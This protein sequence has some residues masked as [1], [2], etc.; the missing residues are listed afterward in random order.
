M[1]GKQGACIL[2]E[3]KVVN[4]PVKTAVRNICLFFGRLIPGKKQTIKH[5]DSKNSVE[6][7]PNT[8]VS[9]SVGCLLTRLPKLK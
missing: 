4:G 7:S 5:E 1:I 3:A 8:D 6:P 2:E 9:E